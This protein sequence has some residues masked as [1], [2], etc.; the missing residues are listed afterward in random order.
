MDDGEVDFPFRLSPKE[1]EVIEMH[2]DP[3]HSILL[4]GRSGTGKTTCA[5]YRIWGHW[6]A[7]HGIGRSKPYHQVFLTA[8]AT[9]KEQVARAFRK[10]QVRGLV[11]NSRFVFLWSNVSAL[12]HVH[13]SVGWCSMV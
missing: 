10:L 7:H 9:L 4:L 1:Q 11:Q 5:V 8:S 13:G 2:P 12:S 6:V 3:P